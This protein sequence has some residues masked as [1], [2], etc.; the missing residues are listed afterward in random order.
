MVGWKK[1]LVVNILYWHTVVVGPYC[2]KQKGYLCY[3][4][5]FWTIVTCWKANS[6]A[7]L[8]KIT[9]FTKRLINFN[10]FLLQFFVQY[11]SVCDKIKIQ[12]MDWW[13]KIFFFGMDQT[14]VDRVMCSSSIGYSSGTNVPPLP[15]SG[16]LLRVYD[17]N[18]LVCSHAW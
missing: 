14:R 1:T 12:L 3:E 18:T 5:N 8:T 6:T 4:L 17:S 11:P 2:F 13:V 16:Y 7:W 15:K 9:Q 10:F